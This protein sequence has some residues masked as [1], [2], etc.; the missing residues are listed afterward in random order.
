MNLESFTAKPGDLDVLFEVRSEK[1]IDKRAGV[2]EPSSTSAPLPRHQPGERF[3]RG[4]IPLPWFKAASSCGGR[5]EAVAVLLWY[6]A[7]YQRR[8][9]VKLTPT[10]LGE[11]GVHPK[12]ARR[13]LGRMSDRGLVRCVFARWRSPV[14]TIVS[15][16]PA[17]AE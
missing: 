13:V 11:L 1:R 8:N 2:A 9:P 17:S 16:D 7:G 6:A 5:A 12:T 10:I 14:V 3:I 4:P 15:P